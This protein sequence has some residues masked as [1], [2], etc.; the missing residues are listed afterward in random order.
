MVNTQPFKN[1][2]LEKGWAKKQ[3]FRKRLSQNYRSNR[4][5]IN[6]MVLYFNIICNIKV[7]IRVKSL[8]HVE[9][10]SVVL[11]SADS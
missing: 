3:P 10:I 6:R 7:N 1:N 8:R 5:L 4:D 9:R 2:L 11:V